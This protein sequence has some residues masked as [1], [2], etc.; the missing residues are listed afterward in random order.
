[1]RK[2][3]VI[4]IFTLLILSFQNCTKKDQ[5]YKYALENCLKNEDLE[6]ISFQD[7]LEKTQYTFQVHKKQRFSRE[8]ASIQPT[9]QWYMNG[10]LVIED[11]EA[12]TKKFKKCDPVEIKAELKSCDRMISSIKKF[13]P[14]GC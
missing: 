12:Y 1:M 3:S 4:L 6:I 13:T 10:E 14:Q 9:I 7:V 11:G 2:I 5:A 8:A